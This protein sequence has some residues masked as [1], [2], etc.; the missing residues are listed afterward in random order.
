MYFKGKKRYVRWRH[1]AANKYIFTSGNLCVISDDI[2][3]M[4]LIYKNM[5]QEHTSLQNFTIFL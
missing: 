5:F 3:L 4:R 1:F 2:D